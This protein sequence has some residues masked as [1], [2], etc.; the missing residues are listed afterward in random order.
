MKEKISYKRRDYEAVADAPPHNLRLARG[1]Y[2]KYQVRP[3]RVKVW[4]KNDCIAQIASNFFDW[5]SPRCVA[6]RKFH[7]LTLPT[8]YWKEKLITLKT[9]CW[10]FK[11]F[12]VKLLKS[13]YILRIAIIIILKC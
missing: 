5:K 2:L 10:Q 13:I 12:K 7:L 3:L 1:K 11:F 4:T 6:T 9:H 8:E